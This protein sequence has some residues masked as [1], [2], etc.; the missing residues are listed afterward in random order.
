MTAALNI[1]KSMAR[2]PAPNAPLK[3]ADFTPPGGRLVPDRLPRKSGIRLLSP[4]MMGGRRSL[5]LL[6]AT[7]EV[8]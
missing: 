3:G 8:R 2:C 6:N 1:V 4:V 7:T 5:D